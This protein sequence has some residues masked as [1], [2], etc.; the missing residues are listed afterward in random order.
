[1]RNS[2]TQS[3]AD[4]NRRMLMATQTPTDSLT[5]R[6]LPGA[7]LL[8]ISMGTFF[9]YGF[10]LVITVGTKYGWLWSLKGIIGVG[11]GIAGNYVMWPLIVILWWNYWRYT[12][13][14]THLIAVHR[15][16]RERVAIPWEAIV[17]VRKR[18][19]PWWVWGGNIA[20]TDI[21]TA[22]GQC[23]PFT[24]NTLLYYERFLEELKARA[25]NCREFDPCLH[26]W[27]RAK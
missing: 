3:W 16:R 11:V 4:G 7:L 19:R 6:H 5:F 17:A 12:F 21:E 26:A 27:D 22:D 2:H 23:L 13:T 24:A 20:L 9:V 10:Y 18:S 14:P 15:L 25:V 1:M 8:M